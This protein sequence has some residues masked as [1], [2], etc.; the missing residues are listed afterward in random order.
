MVSRVLSALAAVGLV[1][2]GTAK[3]PQAQAKVPRK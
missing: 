1:A 2:S 3:V